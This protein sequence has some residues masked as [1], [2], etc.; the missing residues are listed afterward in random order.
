MVRKNATVAP[1]NR[2]RFQFRQD[3]AGEPAAAVRR[4]GPDP[5]ELRRVVVVPA[6]RAAGYGLAVFLDHQERTARSLEF[7]RR[8]AVE[9][10]GRGSADRAWVSCY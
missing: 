9:F 4:V 7:R 10:L 8:V 2:Q 1:A 5:L 6:E 3:E